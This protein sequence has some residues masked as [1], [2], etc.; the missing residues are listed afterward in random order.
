MSSEP[1]SNRT[2]FK[3]WAFLSYSH[4]DKH[5]GDW[6]HKALETYRVPSRL[7]GKD[8]RDGKVPPRVFPIFRDREELPVS[9]DLSANINEALRESRYL[10]VICSPASAQSRWVGEEIKTYKKLGREDRILALIVEGEPNASDGKLGFSPEAECFPQALRYQWPVDEES[11][12][13]RS[14]PIAADVREDK[15]GKLNAKLK[16][17]AGLLGVN[18]DDLKRR[19]QERRIRRLRIVVAVTLALVS[20]F[21]VL[22]VYAWR[23]KQAAES[24]LAQTRQTLSQS[25]YL[26]ALRA[27]GEN[28][29]PDALAQLARSLVLDP[30]NEAALCRLTTLLTYGGFDIPVLRFKH[31]EEV[32]CAQF[33]PDGKKIVTASR[34]GTAVVWDAKSGKALTPALKHDQIVWFAQFSPDSARVL[35]VSDQT[36]R[37]WNVSDGKPVMEPLKQKLITSAQFSPD[38][39][40]IVITTTDH[41]AQIYDARTGTPS[42]QPLKHAGP[43]LS[44]Q[45]STDGTRIATASADKTARIWDA[46]SGRALTPPLQHS[47][48]VVSARFS[49]D[50]QR[51]VTASRDWSARI[52]DAR[53]GELQ[54]DIMDNRDVEFAQFT[55]DG[56]RVVTKSADKDVSIWDAQSGK[57]LTTLHHEYVIASVEL[58]PDGTK[59]VTA[60]G[61]E[62]TINV[63]S[64]QTGRLL[65]DPFK[66]D[67]GVL[68]ARFSPDGKQIV[69]ASWDGTARIWNLPT[70]RALTQPLQHDFEVDAAEFSPDGKRILTRSLNALR[71]WDAQTSE[72]VTEVKEQAGVFDSARFSPDSKL[73]L[74]VSD[75]TAHIWNAEDGQPA[76][77]PLNTGDTMAFAQFSPDGKR[78]VSGTKDYLS[79][80]NVAQVW[81]V[82]TRKLRTQGLKIVAPLNWAG[83]SG[84]GKRLVTASGN[85][86]RIW[87]SENGRLLAGPMN[88]QGQ[89]VWTQFDPADGRI[90]TISGNDARI[91]DAHSGNLL[92]ELKLDGAINPP[93]FSPDGN[94]ILTASMDHTARIWDAKNG[95]PIAQPMKHDK[96]VNSA[97]FSPDGK[98]IVTASNDHTARIWDAQSGTPV[99][100][101]LRHESDVSSA[102][103]SPDGRQIVTASKD[104]TARVWDF[105]PASKSTPEWLPRLAEAVAGQHLDDRGVFEPSD[106]DPSQVLSEIR[107]KLRMAP[108]DTD[109]ATWGRWFLADRS[110]RTI[111]PFSRITIPQYIENRI[112][113]GTLESL[114]EAERLALVHTE[115]M[116][117]I[118]QARAELE[119]KNPTK[120]PQPN[121]PI[122]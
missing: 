7:V 26:Q 45:F 38:G 68:S 60:G 27:I 99:T 102:R 21:G 84:D 71:I 115:I 20:G 15:D 94:W 57:I 11:F 100:D 82:P 93:Q 33:S 83:F 10:I 77:E 58:S 50:G 1:A 25:D 28:R 111:S 121:G 118:E 119:V 108:A 54:I 5:W 96:P 113:V 110:R 76:A 97:Q 59:I 65:F 44:A 4:K 67:S 106:T 29:I 55:P 39:T 69:S 17:L 47:G 9:A 56:R 117:R 73:I 8:S 72:L 61:H 31:H 3:Y 23:Q 16:L 62:N 87:D 88:H 51:L 66:H 19:E 34:D 63:W 85:A 2:G 52:W 104:R 75:G 120:D 114:D 89:I 90:V 53:S 41:E 103:F 91:W 48:E 24:A 80:E 122:K 92:T 14:E 18:Y 79:L 98:R 116:K 42:T 105:L 43:V 12:A 112:K 32:L 109:W 13:A 95:K 22:S 40:H 86:A 37:I 74:G 46:Q 64:T 78:I 81:D 6:L 101:S 107:E 70:G 30:G 49:P 36:A 35:T